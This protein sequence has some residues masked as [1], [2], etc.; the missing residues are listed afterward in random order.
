MFLYNI[1]NVI[2]EI[3]CESYVTAEGSNTIYEIIEKF[4]PMD[5]NNLRWVLASKPIPY[6]FCLKSE[7]NPIRLDRATFL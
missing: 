1:T 4:E 6:L 2:N 3:V 5:A 7:N